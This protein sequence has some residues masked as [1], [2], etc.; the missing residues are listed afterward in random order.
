[1]RYSTDTYTVAGRNP[2]GSVIRLV[3]PQCAMAIVD[4]RN[5]YITALIGGRQAPTGSM[6][7]NR[8]YQSTMPVGS[9]IKPL[10]VYG[11]AIEKGSG[12]GTVY[13]DYQMKIE[14]WDSVNGYPANNSR[15]YSGRTTMRRAFVQSLN[16]TAAQAL[17]YD[18]GLDDAYNT[19][20]NLGVEPS[21]ISKTGSGLAL[22][23]SGITPLE[24]AG[25]YSAI[26]NMGEYIQPIAFT[27]VEDHNGNVILD[28]LSKQQRR[29]VF[30]ESTAWQITNLMRDVATSNSRTNVPGQ[31]V[32]GKT[33]TNSDNRGVFFAGF[34]GYY[35]GCVWIGSDAYKPLTSSAQGGVYGAPL[36]A[37]VMTEVHKGLPNK[38]ANSVDPASI[39]VQKVEYCDHSGKLA[40]EACPSKH[41]DYGCPEKM[42]PC[43]LHRH[44]TICKTSGML[45]TEFCPESE[46]ETATIILV[47][48][49][50]L[51]HYMYYN[52][53]N[54]FISLIGTPVT[55][56]SSCKLHT[57]HDGQNDSTPDAGENEG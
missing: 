31:T 35:V 9:S 10:A 18:V 37:A 34:T 43:D 20:V 44:V 8:S 22:G 33:G 26:A 41:T 6:Q 11:P 40:T 48:Q 24:M 55:S 51:L 7:F 28:M 23:S 39:G 32:Y 53:N 57:Q 4:Y 13:Y 30:S 45:A 16:V 52:E 38:P 12:A 46:R 25:A 19:L 27:R 49:R 42:E 14:G 2:D 3:Q 21:H 1:M 15:S 47:P 50:G 54:R 5:G 17:M 56:M 36:F 29:R